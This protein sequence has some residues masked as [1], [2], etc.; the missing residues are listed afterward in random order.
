MPKLLL[1]PTTIDKVTCPEGRKRIDL[2]DTRTR[3]LMLEVRPQGKTYYLRYQTIRG[4]TRQLRLANAGDVTLAQARHLAEQARNKIAMGE[5]PAQTR[6]AQ[7]AV[8]TF[9]AFIQDQYIPY[10]KTYKRSWDTDVSLLKNHLLPRFGNMHLDEITRLDI[11]KVHIDRRA[12]GAAPGSA[13]RL[14]ILMR[15]VFNLAIKWEVPGVKANPSKDIPLMEEN[16]KLERYLTQDEAH[17]LY[18]AV[19][20]SENPMLRFIMPMLLMT[21]A[22]KK[23]V[24]NARWEDFD[25]ERR[26]WRVPI[27]KTGKARHVPLSNGVLKLLANLPRA[28]RCPYLFPNP[29]TGKPYVSAFCAWNTARKNAGLPKV[30]MHDLRHSF[31]SFLINGGRSLYEVQRI[32][33]H[34]QSKTTQ[35]YAHLRHDTL[36]DAADA[37]TEAMGQLMLPSSTQASPRL[38]GSQQ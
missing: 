12:S 18:D 34:T 5:D 27:S 6:A 23:E 2:F 16:N 31:A 35:R 15:Y 19:C 9:A 4:K 32:L 36:L 1:K 33:G 13:N 21:G 10:I 26:L 17:R 24:L 3:G 37:A 22:R 7:R 38:I 29:A 30:R 25:L 8:P 14:L 28:G 20:G 11:Q